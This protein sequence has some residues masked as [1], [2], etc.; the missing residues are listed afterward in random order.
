MARG[1]AV[2]THP[3]QLWFVP[4]PRLLE[5][6]EPYRCLMCGRASP[7]GTYGPPGLESITLD[8]GQEHT[9][10]LRD[11][12]FCERHARQ[13][14]A[15]YERCR[16][17]LPA[18]RRRLAAFALLDRGGISQRELFQQ[19]EALLADPAWMPLETPMEAR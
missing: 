6:G 19:A 7:S 5:P 1:G 13:R 12:W 2:T 18:R 10:Q 14:W 4:P 16:V 11:T 8:D 9:I 15:H 3:E 17:A